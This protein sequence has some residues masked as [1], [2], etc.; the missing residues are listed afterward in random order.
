MWRLPRSPPKKPKA[1]ISRQQPGALLLLPTT[2][3]FG[4]RI[5][6]TSI[7]GLGGAGGRIPRVSKHINLLLLRPAI[8]PTTTHL[9]IAWTRPHTTK[10]PALAPVPASASSCR[11]SLLA[12]Q[13][14]NRPVAPFLLA[15]K[16]H[17]TSVLSISTSLTGLLLSGLFYAFGAAYVVVPYLGLGW[18][19]SSAGM[20]AAVAGWSV[21]LK[22][23]A[24]M[25]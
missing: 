22:G 18:D 5:A 20:A 16:W 12:R 23:M 8:T 4:D 14:L 7:H 1:L 2:A 10:S 25:R 17:I 19:L 21:F 3:L 15:H 11:T 6:M 9:Y 24:K 13:R